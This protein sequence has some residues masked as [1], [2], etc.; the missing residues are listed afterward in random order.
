V[1]ESIALT[2]E[3]GA[4]YWKTLGTLNKALIS[5]MTAK[6]RDAAQ[7]MASCITAYRS[8]GATFMAPTYLSFLARAFAEVGLIDDA[9]RYIREAV[10]LIETTKEKFIEAEVSRIAGEI[11]LMAPDRDEVKA[12]TFFKRALAVVRAEQTK[13]WEL[14]TATSMAR[15]WRDQGK[16][17]DARELLAPVYGWFTEGFDTCDLKEAKA[18]LE[19]LAS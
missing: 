1:D 9:W 3:K 6:T 13:S 18:L 10:T 8:T 16:R 14:R 5:A 17:D 15:L 19:E 2:D 4:S 11:A 12:L 7:K